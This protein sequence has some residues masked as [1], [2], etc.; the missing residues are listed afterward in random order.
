M[1][2]TKEYKE[3]QRHED[4]VENF[5][6]DSGSD[7]NTERDVMNGG[8][9]SLSSNYDIPVVFAWLSR[10]SNLFLSYFSSLAYIYF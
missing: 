8:M 1:Q 3:S 10:Q 5:L 7:D 4:A 2:L 6:V 9:N